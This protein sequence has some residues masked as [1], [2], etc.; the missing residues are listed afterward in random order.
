MYILVGSSTTAE[1]LKRATERRLGFPAYVVHTPSA[2]STGG[3]SYCVRVDD[4]AL[5]EIR[6]IASESGVPIKNIYIE[7]TEKGERVYHA[8]S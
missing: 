2:I 4:R 1:R 5:G 6:I 8:V 3:C 7:T